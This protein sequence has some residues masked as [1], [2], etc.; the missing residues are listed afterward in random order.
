MQLLS[1]SP[2]LLAVTVFS[3]SSILQIYAEEP[4][5]VVINEWDIPT[6]DSAPHDIVVGTN[7]MIWFTEINVNK[8]G[9]FDPNT[10]EFKEYDIP[11][12][13]SRPHGLVTDDMGNVWF[14]EVSA[15]QIGK[16]DIQTQTIIEYPT[17]TPNSGP[18][19]PI[20]ADQNTLWFTEQRASQIGKITIDSGNIE[21]FPTITPSANPY[22]IITDDSGNAWFAELL[23]HHIGKVDAVTGEVTEFSLPTENSGPR[24]IAIDSNGILWITQYNAGKIA[25]LNPETD[26]IKEYDTSSESSGPYAIWVDPQDNVWFSMTGIYK[27]GKLDQT[28]QE[29][30]EYDMPSPETHIKFIHSDDDGNIWF[31]NYNNNKIGVILADIATVTEHTEEDS[32]TITKT[33]EDDDGTQTAHDIKQDM[34]RSS[35]QSPLKQMANG[36]ASEDVVC[37]EGLQLMIRNNGDDAICVDD[38]SVTE[39]TNRGIATVV[40]T[41]MRESTEDDDDHMND[42][43][44]M[45]ET[46][47]IFE[48]TLEYTTQ[49]AIINDEKGYFVTEI[50]D[51]VYWLVG[52]GYQTMFLTTGQGVVVFDAPKPIGE[53]YLDAINDVTSE[54]ITHMVYSHHHQDHTGAAG[55]IFS[56]DITYI[57]HKDAADVLVSENNPDIPIPTKVLEG[58]TNTLQIGSK[59]IE[60]HNI[61]DFHSKGNLLII[62]PQDKVAMLV[63]LFRPA[64]SPYRAFGVTPDIDLYLETHDVLQTFDFDVLLTGHTNLLAT[65]DDV[66]INKQ[67]TQSVMDNAQTALDSGNSDPSEICNTTTI[68]QWEGKLGNLDEFMGDHCNAMIE[69]LQ[70]K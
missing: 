24:R 33:L 64:E 41:S 46:T 69:H 21:E 61:G 3:F 54:P 2:L 48:K 68:E 19:T 23:G 29:I 62:L 25:S 66:K 28:T 20:F 70:S 11:T 27:M 50:A 4:D 26:E 42:E 51:D 9:M 63:D 31:P 52:S 37:R 56:E 22:G 15:G 14:T 60:F 40:D 59:T 55:Q 32:T 17:P 35:Q 5:S 10:H 45:K 8:I 57:S 6:L 34:A 16:L 38:S 13:S 58:K 67:F 30:Y 7:G 39:I 65:K 44:H 1:L 47:G 18:H 53:K 36:V 49:P 12:P 43:K